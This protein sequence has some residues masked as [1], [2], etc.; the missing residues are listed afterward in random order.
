MKLRVAFFFSKAGSELGLRFLR[1]KWHL[2]IDALSFKDIY[3]EVLYEL[4]KSKQHKSDAQPKS[5]EQQKK[6]RQSRANVSRLLARILFY[7][8]TRIRIWKFIKKLI[9][10]SYK[11]FSLELE[12][13]EVRGTLGDPF[14]NSIALGISGGCYYP[15][16]ENE[17]G[18]WSA[19]GDVTLKTG[20]LR[21]FLFL[22]SLIYQTF[23]LAF[24]LWRGLQ[25][26]RK[27]VQ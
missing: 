27:A 3:E 11:L 25:R 10:R 5:G 12:N 22:F 13:I 21:G 15:H 16:W 2:P 20:F 24:V 23:A 4:E 26:A 6:N 17:N 18:T 7:P 14:Y 8:E 19:K 9:Y 1:W